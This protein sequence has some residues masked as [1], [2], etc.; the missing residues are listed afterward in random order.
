[1]NEEGAAILILYLPL[2]FASG[3]L[4]R[5]MPGTMASFILYSISSAVLPI[6][7]MTPDVFTASFILSK[8]PS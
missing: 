4:K 5:T 1:M 3:L 2:S 8:Y 6:S 7:D